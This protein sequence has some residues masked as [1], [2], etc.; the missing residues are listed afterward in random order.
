MEELTKEQA[1]DILLVYDEIQCG[2]VIEENINK[3]FAYIPEMNEGI[4]TLQK[5]RAINRY[6]IFNQETLL[7]MTTKIIDEQSDQ[8]ELTGAYALEAGVKKPK[9]TKKK[10]SKRSWRSKK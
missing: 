2:N 1:L 5:I 6:V 4:N 3:A 7:N 9:S 8:N 10:K